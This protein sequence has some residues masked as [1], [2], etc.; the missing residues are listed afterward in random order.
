MKSMK[1]PLAD[2]LK[3]SRPKPRDL[4]LR[5]S[6]FPSHTEY[7]RARRKLLDF[8][9]LNS[10]SR[11]RLSTPHGLFLHIRTSA[12]SR[13]IEF[14]LTEEQFFTF[15]NRPCNYCGIELERTHLD[16]IDSRKGY[17][18]GNVVQSCPKCNM[19]KSD[20]TLEEFK[21]WLILAYTH[22]IGIPK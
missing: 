1:M 16:R 15:W 4:R 12:K 18:L 20:M 2:V 14:T 9:Y 13:V 5:L 3:N 19:A 17:E 10:E 11:R 22:T 7:Q 21:E 8:D 6:D